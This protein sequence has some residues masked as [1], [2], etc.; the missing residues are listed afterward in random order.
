MRATIRSIFK[1]NLLYSAH[2]E[3]RDDVHAGLSGANVGYWFEQVFPAM[4]I[5][6]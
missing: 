3:F 6:T 2:T 5:G 1:D 4:P